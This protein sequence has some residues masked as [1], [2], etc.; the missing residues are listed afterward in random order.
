MLNTPSYSANIPSTALF[1]INGFGNTI[2]SASINKNILKETI[3]DRFPTHSVHLAFNNTEG[4]FTDAAQILKQ[5]VAIENDREFWKLIDSD[6]LNTASIIKN[7]LYLKYLNK[8]KNDQLSLPEIQTHINQYKTFLNEDQNVI[9]IPHS[10][11]NF[12]A[13][14]SL[15]LLLASNEVYRKQLYSIGIAT[16]SN[17]LLPNASYFTSSNDLVIN[18]IRIAGMPTLKANV[19]IPFQLSNYQGH[20]FKFYLS[21]PNLKTQLIQKI[22]EYSNAKS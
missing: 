21:D 11:G 20:S 22:G 6:D 16:P 1:Y 13:N 19:K 7:E 14:A 5:R 4:F 18:A 10:Q 15:N 3:R 9:L 12:Y 8:L 17:I 2:D